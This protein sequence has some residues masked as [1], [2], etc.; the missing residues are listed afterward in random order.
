MHFGLI[1][2]HQSGFA[3]LEEGWQKLIDDE[4]NASFKDSIKFEIVSTLNFKNFYY[5]AF[6]NTRLLSKLEF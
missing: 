5:H 1:L 3:E 4:R 2:W 6:F